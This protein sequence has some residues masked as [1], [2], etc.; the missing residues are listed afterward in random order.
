MAIR[1]SATRAF[2]H[3]IIVLLSLASAPLLTRYLG[4]VG[5]GAYMQVVSLIALVG[6]VTEAGLG[7]LALREHAVRHGSDRDRLMR[8]L[9]GIRLV[10]TVVGVAGATVFAALAGYG[11]PLVLG[12]LLAGAGLLTYVAQAAFSVGLWA[13]LRL[14]WVTAVD[15]LRHLVVVLVIVALV[16]TDAGILA[17][18]AAPIAGGMVAMPLTIKLV[19]GQIPLRPAFERAV[20]RAI[21]R[22][23][24]SL[25]VAGAVYH[26][27]FRVVILVM[28]VIAAGLQTGYYA[29]AF[30]IVEAVIAVPFLLV[31][32]LLPVLARA[33]RDDPE[34]FAFGLGRTYEVSIIAGAW[35]GLVTGLGAGFAID[36]LTDEPAAA[37]V[38]VLRILS[39]TVLL[40]FVSITAG[41]A[42]VTMRRHRELLVG[43][44]IALTVTLGATL[45]LVPPLGARGGALA[46]VLGE[47]SLVVALV[48]LV[49]RGRPELRPRLV[50]VPRVV[51]ATAIA[52]ALPVVAGVHAVAAVALAT[53]LYFAVLTAL[54]GI[55]AE[56]TDALLPERWH[57]ARNGAR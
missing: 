51:V 45:A 36:V 42:L 12:T 32:A 48:A 5:F 27:Y 20:W 34:R 2:G 31:G 41:T 3:G 49:A 37:A 50:N 40:A 21:L 55:P 39:L 16:L 38:D 43:N 9:L 8:N 22:E 28:S 46:T 7:A 29:L 44:A 11:R 19:R 6:L 33:A 53:V 25:A 47:A 18:L 52:V 23:T 15:V 14:G 10:L 4:V 54:R 1:G 17:L 30:R 26:M 24:V 13:Q 57:A 35:M 56:L